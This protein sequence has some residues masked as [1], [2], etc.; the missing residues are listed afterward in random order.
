MADNARLAFT[1]QLAV[2]R[3]CPDT[4]SALL[5]RE[6]SLLLASRVL[7]ISRLLYA[8]LS[9][10]PNP[11]PYLEKVKDRLATL[12]RRLLST[13]DRC[14]K[15]VDVQ[16]DELVEAMCAFS[17]ATSSTAADAVRHFQHLRLEAMNER[18]SDTTA[19]K[20][21]NM[22][23]ALRLYIQTL[24]DTR[25]VAPGQLSSAL[26]SLKAVPIFKSQDLL[27][28]EGLNLDLHERGIGDDIKSF[29]PYVRHD[30]L[31]RQKVGQMLKQWATMAIKSFLQ[32]LKSN[33]QDIND[34]NQVMKLRV[35]ILELWLS[36]HQHSQGVNSAEVLDGL[37]EVFNEQAALLNQRTCQLLKDFGEQVL[38]TVESWQPDITDAL[39]SLWSLGTT[40]VGSGNSGKAFRTK[41][42]DLS[43]GKTV[44][45]Q[46][47]VSAYDAWL[48]N[49]QTLENIIQEAK[50]NRWADSIDEADDDDDQ[51]LENKQS[52]LSGDDPRTLEEALRQDLQSVF[53]SLT[54]TLTSIDL[55]FSNQASQSAFL[56]RVWR[57]VR[58]NLPATLPRQDLGHDE[59]PK[60]FKALARVTLDSPLKNCSKR[61]D[62]T[63]RSLTFPARAVW[64]GKPELPVLPS[65]WCYRLLLD[66][67]QAMARHGTDIWSAEAV[68]ALKADLRVR[69]AVLLTTEGEEVDAS[70]G[71]HHVNGDVSGGSK[72]KSDNSRTEA[73]ENGDRMAEAEMSGTSDEAQ[74]VDKLDTHGEDDEASPTNKS[75]DGL[76]NGTS[77][78]PPDAA[79]VESKQTQRL[80]DISYLACATDVKRKAEEND[81][82][83]GLANN[84]Q[85]SILKK[86][87][88]M[89]DGTVE[90]IRNNAAEYWKRTSLLFG[91]LQ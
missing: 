44:A 57:H 82:V 91:L 88:T 59:I 83:D 84:I 6:Q 74:D 51:L 3:S 87:M 66:V 12:R 71:R 81:T 90:R 60:L 85:D 68:K 53:A 39:P 9:K 14:F 49:V 27:T 46:R 79:V 10:R 55:D 8:K 62:R 34:P 33:I 35:E 41:V 30:D 22:S 86:A 89:E 80:F 40:S 73:I 36:Q 16:K 2:L 61:L 21:E 13:I 4:I 56:V 5:K 70:V 48:R 26:Q 42:V 11:P 18:M 78:S 45:I 76:I 20:Y 58:R 38:S 7:V 47:L 77:N 69:L 64:E 1:C 25:A 29:T 75:N 43:T 72:S 52:L 37:R 54:G 32:R 15:C 50:A 24:R 67:V 23:A 65:P 63:A 19:E 31:D 28:L 17:L